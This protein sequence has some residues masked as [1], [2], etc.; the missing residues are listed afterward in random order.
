MK[1]VADKPGQAAQRREEMSRSA[2]RAAAQRALFEAPESASS[3]VENHHLAA[4]AH[5]SPGSTSN[6]SLRRSQSS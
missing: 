4:A 5:A 3:E 2:Q 1:A 6:Q